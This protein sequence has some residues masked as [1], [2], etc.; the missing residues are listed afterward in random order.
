MA[1]LLFN[2]A[3]FA[4]ARWIHGPAHLAPVSVPDTSIPLLQ[5]AHSDSGPPAAATPAAPPSSTAA[6]LGPA[7]PMHCRTVGPFENEA[8]LSAAAERLHT[9]GWATR[10]RSV[11]NTIP[12]GY[13]VYIGYLKDAAAQ[14]HMVATLN[15]AGIRD[16]AVMTA[17]ENSDRVSLG[18]FVDHA[19]AMHRAEQVRELG[20]KPVLQVHQR[21]V[22]QRWLDFDRSAAD[23]DPAPADLQ[24]GSVPLQLSDCPAKS[25]S[26]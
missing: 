21:T 11:E 5:L 6:A 16:A 25:A 1:L 24:S 26:G 19:H 2:F 7:A 8:E 10:E 22:S 20:L 15:A 17:P 18:V 9:R 14:H 12:D 23:P 13:W 3:F 4:W